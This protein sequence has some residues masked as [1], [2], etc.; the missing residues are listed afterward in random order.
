MSGLSYLQTLAG[1][2]PEVE[3]DVK[4]LSSYF[5]QKLW[6]QLTQKLK[7]LL[8][9]PFFQRPPALL[10]LYNKFVKGFQENVNQLELALFAVAASRQLPELKQA[11]DFL[12]AL[13]QSVKAD[14]EASVLVST[15][16]AT[17]L[18]AS[19]AV[20][21]ATQ[22]LDDAKKSIEEFKGIMDAVVNSAYHRAR[23]E[24]SR[25][26]D[27]PTEVFNS[28]L[29]YLSYTPIDRIPEAERIEFSFQVSMAALVGREIFN[30][31]ELLERPVV[32]VLE[33]GK[34]AWALDLL[35]AFNEGD[36]KTYEATV[37]K[38]ADNPQIA[39]NR[40][41]LNQKVRIMRLMNIVFARS[42][43]DRELQ[44]ADIAA[45]CDTKLDQV[46]FLLMKA[47]S[48]KVIKGRIDQ[49]DKTVTISWLLPRVLSIGQVGEMSKRLK[50]WSTEVA[51]TTKRVEANS[52][53]MV[54]G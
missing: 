35:K 10:D 46:E 29:L 28:A 9:V 13:T 45:A 51:T 17:R 39:K 5:Q 6:Y 2:A 33:D 4:E 15:E 12:D 43:Q 40:G 44:F 7:S 18:A 54:V 25:R 38:Y 50:Q 30:F 47:F 8:G 3:D 14:S 37:A 16:R 36:V 27:D 41:F 1:G 19:G 31:G 11:Q 52:K 53:D 48:L 24:V 20:D 22:I 42:S 26:K 21:D 34:Y 23:F 49:V 32:R